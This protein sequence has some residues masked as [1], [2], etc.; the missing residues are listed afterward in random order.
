MCFLRI[1]H[2]K[3]DGE[4]RRYMQVGTSGHNWPFDQVTLLVV[5]VAY[6]DDFDLCTNADELSW[7]CCIGLTF[8]IPCM[9]LNWG[10]GVG[11]KF[12]PM[13]IY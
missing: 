2:V 4:V 6:V 5:K 12:Y 11:L 9:L 7:Y 13:H 10:V 8:L 3:V 1:S